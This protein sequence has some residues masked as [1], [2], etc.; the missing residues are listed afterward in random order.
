M[1]ISEEPLYRIDH[2]SVAEAVICRALDGGDVLAPP[3]DFR[4]V[5]HPRLRTRGYQ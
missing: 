1:L 2:Y 5:V 4:I 3:N